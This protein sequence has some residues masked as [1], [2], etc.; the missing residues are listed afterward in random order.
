MPP[1]DLVRVKN[2]PKLTPNSHVHKLPYYT[3]QTKGKNLLRK[4][5]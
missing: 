3:P 5:N 4:I 1:P 2:T